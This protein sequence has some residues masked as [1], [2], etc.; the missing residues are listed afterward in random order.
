[1]SYND[2][3]NDN[4]KDGSAKLIGWLIVIVLS[5]L[6]IWFHHLDYLGIEWSG[7]ILGAILNS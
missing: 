7:I 4:N 6:A 2:G 3:F 5:G 1:M